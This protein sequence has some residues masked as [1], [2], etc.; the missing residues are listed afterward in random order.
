[1]KGRRIMAIIGI[2]ILV[3]LYVTT[4]L[5]AVFGNENTTPWFM[6]SIAATLV[7]PILLWVYGW[8]YKRLKTDM[9][10]VRNKT[11]IR[12]DTDKKE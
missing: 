2:I 5:L 10:D 3:G 11:E 4:L 12:N 8:I 6:A 1:M 7:L 9:D